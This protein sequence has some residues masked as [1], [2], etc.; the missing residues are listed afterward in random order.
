MPR[1]LL[2][3]RF[4]IAR[5]GLPRKGCAKRRPAFT[6]VFFVL[7]CCVVALVRAGRSVAGPCIP[8]VDLGGLSPQDK[9]VFAV[10]FLFLND[11]VFGFDVDA[12]VG[13]TRRR[14]RGWALHLEP[15]WAD[16]GLVIR[17]VA[18]WSSH[19]QSRLLLGRHAVMPFFPLRRFWWVARRAMQRSGWREELP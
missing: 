14:Q 16:F 5:G 11:I 4:V 2:T 19:A 15:F 6:R 17:I 8:F 13:A 12:R 9:Q 7:V 1:A 3:N 10:S 18:K